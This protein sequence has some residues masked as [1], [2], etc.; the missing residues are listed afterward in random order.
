MKYLALGLNLLVIDFSLLCYGTCQAQ[1]LSMSLAILLQNDLLG[2]GYELAAQ[3][4]V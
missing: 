1:P 4:Y 3:H 2:M